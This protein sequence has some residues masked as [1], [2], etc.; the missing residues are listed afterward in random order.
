M[1]SSVAVLVSLVAV[2]AAT[3]VSA[4][5]GEQPNNATRTIMFVQDNQHGDFAFVDNAPHSPDPN[6]DSPKARFSL[7]DEAIFHAALRDHRGGSR[8]GHVYATE[9]VVRGSRYPNV[10]NLIHAVI[11]F[12]DGQVVVDAVIDEAHPSGIRAAVTGGTGAYEGASGTLI[13]PAGSR[14]YFELVLQR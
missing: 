11:V 5:G 8:I 10:T 7:G 2:C 14:H 13:P 12:D 1:K 6:P 9:T 3:T 4:S